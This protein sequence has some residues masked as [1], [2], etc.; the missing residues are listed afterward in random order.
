MISEAVLN[1][2]AVSQQNA[3]SSE[4]I[5]TSIEELNNI[6]TIVDSKVTELNKINSELSE[7]VSIF[8]AD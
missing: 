8:K 5:M 1:L 3:A 6:M 4:E 2:S 7:Y